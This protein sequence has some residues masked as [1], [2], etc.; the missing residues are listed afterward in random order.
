M[1]TLQG[2]QQAVER[3]SAQLAERDQELASLEARSR[4]TPRGRRAAIVRLEQAVLDMGA[5]ETFEGALHALA[6]Q[7]RLVVGAHQ[8]AVSYVPE[9]NFE[10]A[11]HT[12]S[13]PRS[14]RGTIR[15]T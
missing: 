8:S 14:T 10:A 1:T 12:H 13:F 9:G 5:A 3:L 15:T 7:A 2:L 11:I 6:L 4:V